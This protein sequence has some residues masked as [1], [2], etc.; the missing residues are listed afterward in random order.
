MNKN[1]INCK[2][3]DFVPGMILR[4]TVKGVCETGV[5]VKMPR[6]RGSGVISLR[7]WGAGVDR[8]KALAAIRP[9]DEFD[10][11]VR[12]FDARATTLSL[13]LADC[14]QFVPPP[15]NASKAMRQGALRPQ[16]ATCSRKPEFKPI[17]QGTVLLWDASNLLGAIKAENAAHT[18]ETVAQALSD[19]GYGTMFFLERRCLAWARYSQRTA[20]DADALDA[21]ARRSDVVLVENGGTG[22]DEADCAIL[23]MAE[24]LPDSV[25][26]SR[27]RFGDYAQ[28]Y[29]NIVGTSRVRSFSV[30]KTGGKTMI[31]VNGVVHAIV[32][33]DGNMKSAE[34]PSLAANDL[35]GR[36]RILAVADGCI[37]RGNVERAVR[38][39]AKAAKRDPLAYRALAK[40][41]RE[42]DAVSADRKKAL[43]YESLARTHEKTIRARFVR[44][45]RR[46]AES[47]RCGCVCG[48][49]SAKRKKALRMALF[50]EGHKA[51]RDYFK[52]APRRARRMFGHAA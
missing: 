21:F 32:V 40:M 29:P 3:G 38:I 46:R 23:Q 7:C 19:H 39:Y 24:A 13:V 47:I 33:E 31:L 9:G 50:A 45:R 36:S 43:H 4:A 25:C 41:Y 2:K 49:F 5:M 16:G 11:V 22:A 18:L 26:V 44:D 20:A 12:L 48:H 1:V 15:G 42:G 34:A 8:E 14:G 37:R 35:V 30:A 10:V 52:G 51:I 27:D 17:E 28:V 6:G